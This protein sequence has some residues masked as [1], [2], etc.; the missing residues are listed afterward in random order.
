MSSKDGG[1]V[2][3]TG[4][5]GTVLITRVGDGGSAGIGTESV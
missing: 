2:F 1:T 3:M 4:D 5:G